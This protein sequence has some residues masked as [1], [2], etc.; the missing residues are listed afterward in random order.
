MKNKDGLLWLVLLLLLG[1]VFMLFK[2]YKNLS[3]P[4][5]KGTIVIPDI[6]KIN[7][8]GELVGSDFAG[9]PANWDTA[10]DD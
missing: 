4:K 10:S 1:A 7:Q 8:Y 6:E 2:M 3:K 9:R 5:L